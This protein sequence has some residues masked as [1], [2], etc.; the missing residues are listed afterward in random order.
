M[1][2]SAVDF[3]RN[4]LSFLNRYLPI[5]MVPHVKRFLALLLAGGA[6]FIP[7]FNFAPK[8]YQWF[9]KDRMSKLFRRLRIVEEAMQEELSTPQIVALQNN[10]ENIN[11]AARI[12]PKRNSDLFFDFNQH[13][14]ST[15]ARLA[16]RLV[17]VRNQ[18]LKPV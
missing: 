10:F 15:R 17:E 11:R 2:E 5:W 16:S 4:G 7:V 9:L 1:A 12:L 13:I 3:Y 6:I 14:E 8:L 18:T